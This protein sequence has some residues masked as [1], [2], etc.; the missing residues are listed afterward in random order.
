MINCIQN[1][2][3]NNISFFIS[4]VVILLGVYRLF[5]IC[6]SLYLFCTHDIAIYINT[7]LNDIWKKK[8]QIMVTGSTSGIGLAIVNEL[9]NIGR[10]II[11]HGRDSAKIADITCQLKKTARNRINFINLDLS[12]IDNIEHYCKNLENIFK[13]NP[14]IDVIINNAGYSL[15]WRFISTNYS[16]AIEFYNTNII[17]LICITNSYITYK[18]TQNS[19]SYAC[20]FISSGLSEIPVPYYNSYPFSKRLGNTYYDFIEYSAKNKNIKTLK[21]SY[22]K[23]G[24]VITKNN[25]VMYNAY[26]EKKKDNPKYIPKFPTLLPVQ[27]AK[28]ILKTCLVTHASY[29]HLYHYTIST[30]AK[31]IYSIFGIR[32]FKTAMKKKLQYLVDMEKK[33]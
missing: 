21:V 31:F 6:R 20:V 12:K 26:K 16:E 14:E 10:P 4:F 22:V 2:I 1:L 29:G 23:V 30:I 19:S 11:I 32:L 7:N 27:A 24:W 13:N 8:K 9:T 15:K 25:I 3:Y 17:A 28:G 5:D 33:I 18:K